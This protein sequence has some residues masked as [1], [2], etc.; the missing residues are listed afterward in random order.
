MVG[1]R[2][3][4]K[5]F[6]VQ[7]ACSYVSIV[8]LLVL[9]QARIPKPQFPLVFLP[10]LD[11]KYEPL[12][13]NDLV[14]APFSHDSALN[15]DCSNFKFLSFTK[16]FLSLEASVT[17]GIGSQWIFSKSLSTISYMVIC[18]DPAFL[19]LSSSVLEWF[20]LLSAL[21]CSRE[22]G[23]C[24]CFLWFV[25]HVAN[26]MCDILLGFLSSAG[27]YFCRNKNTWKVWHTMF[28]SKSLTVM[29]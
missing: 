17:A 12:K 26:D 25:E 14:L 15:Y 22:N 20:M 2:T 1:K 4:S 8:R 10:I 28:R 7:N 9:Q 27:P 23:A 24:D 13:R 18:I 6:H 11:L 3:A 5:P 29:T 19:D 21:P 16:S